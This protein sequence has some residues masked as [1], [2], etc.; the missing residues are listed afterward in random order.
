MALNQL[1]E[2]E[3]SNVV[4]LMSTSYA[5]PRTAEMT[6]PTIALMMNRM[7]PSMIR[8]MKRLGT[9]AKTKPGMP[10]VLAGDGGGG[11]P[12]RCRWRCWCRIRRRGGRARGLFCHCFRLPP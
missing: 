2:T 11:S 1:V 6:A 5:G 9:S 8:A 7:I 12:A 4:G 3:T 10:C